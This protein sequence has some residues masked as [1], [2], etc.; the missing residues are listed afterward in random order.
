[1]HVPKF[2]PALEAMPNFKLVRH[3]PLNNW[4]VV[5]TERGRSNRS[6]TG[7]D[8]Q[9]EAKQVLKAYIAEYV[10]KRSDTKDAT[11]AT[12]LR[13]YQDERGLG[14]PSEKANDQ[15]LKLFG[16]VYGEDMLVSELTPSEHLK[17]EKHCRTKYKHKP[18]SINKRRTVLLA[19]LN[20]A[21]ANNVLHL[22]PHV[23]MLGLPPRKERYLTRDEAAKLI[24]EARRQK[25]WH[26]VLFIR[27]GLYTAARATAILELTWDRVDL[28]QGRIDFR[29]PDE[30]ETK[31][32]RPNA[33]VNF[34]LVRALRAARKK[35]N[36][37][38]VIA[39][40]GRSIGLIRKSF[41]KVAEDAGVKKV[42]PHTLKHT[43]ITWMLQNRLTPWQVSG[44]TNTSVPTLL[45]V[46]GHH[47]DSDLR[48]AANVTPRR[49]VN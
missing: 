41:L 10:S 1:V 38:H 15:A 44:L 47:V 36:H 13:Q 30:V 6:S 2:K 14:S 39:Y 5:W 34:K 11:I 12:I 24:R 8:N 16:E 25:L 22:V 33:H 20:Y 18:S 26:L 4:Y 17:F 28:V 32:R 27:V 40:Q 19:A 37:S 31:K 7:T 9:T 48:E 49:M 21:K 3:G 42:S 35:T 23:P 46:Y 45:R 43:C 29:L